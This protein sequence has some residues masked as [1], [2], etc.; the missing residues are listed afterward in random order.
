MSG[1]VLTISGFH[2]SISGFVSTISGYHISISGFMSTIGGYLISMMIFLSSTLSSPAFG[3]LSMVYKRI[4][5]DYRRFSHVYERI[6]VE[7]QRLSH[8]YQRIR[9]DY[10]RFP[11]FYDRSAPHIFPIPTL[12]P[13]KSAGFY[14]ESGCSIHFPPR[15]QTLYFTNL[16]IVALPILVTQHVQ[17]LIR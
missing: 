3:G 2:M 6:C 15:F 5:V 12:E 17:W 10:R 16:L 9:V 13:K 14:K 4:C 7:Y 1:F 8:V 11:N